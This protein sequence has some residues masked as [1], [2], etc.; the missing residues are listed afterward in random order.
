ML[1]DQ[2]VEETDGRKT[3]SQQAEIKRRQSGVIKLHEL[4]RG[5][6]HRIGF[7]QEKRLRVASK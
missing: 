4:D 2:E 5:G 3:K 6:G 7:D 1:I